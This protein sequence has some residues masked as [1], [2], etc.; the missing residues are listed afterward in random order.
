[1]AGCWREAQM[2]PLAPDESSWHSANLGPRGGVCTWPPRP[3]SSR[4]DPKWRWWLGWHCISRG[5]C[6]A[7]VS[8]GWWMLSSLLTV[9]VVKLTFS[10]PFNSWCTNST[11]LPPPP[12]ECIRRGLH[13]LYPFTLT[14]TPL[15][16]PSPSPSRSFS[17]SRST[18]SYPAPPTVP[19]QEL[20]SSILG[21][22]LSRL[23]G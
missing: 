6:C 18:P 5:I 20:P 3:V 15:P 11:P 2:S 10:S 13:D 1:M 22:A 12:Y 14:L 23:F 8:L 17:L 16:S 9:E 19:Q 21:F 4:S 7:Q